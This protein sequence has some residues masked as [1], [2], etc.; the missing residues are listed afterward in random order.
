MKQ[1]AIRRLLSILTALAV[2]LTYATP[3]GVNMPFGEKI[4]SDAYGAE[5]HWADPFMNK[6]VRDGV[7]QGNKQGELNPEMGITRAEFITMINRAFGY[8]N[9]GANKFTDVPQDAW[10]ANDISIASKQGYFTGAENNLAK[11]DDVLKRE[12]AV[13]LLCRA[14][15]IEGSPEDNFKFSDSRDFSYW[16]KDYIYAATQKSYING[17]PDQTFK[18]ANQMKRGEMSKVLADVTGSLVQTSGDTT[19][20]YTA[21]NV[22]LNTSG[23]TLRNTTVPGDL[24]ITGGV[25][26][27]YTT[28]DN[29]TV[30][31]DLIVSGAGESNRGGDSIVL[32]DCNIRTMIIDSSSGNK[33]SVRAEGN[34]E[35][36][37]TMVKSNAYLEEANVRYSAFKDLELNGPSGT[38]LDLS[39]IFDSTIIYGPSNTLSLNK[40]YISRLHVDEQAASAKVYMEDTSEINDV[41]LDVGTAI[42][43]KGKIVNI[44]IGT[45]GSNV[46]MLPQNIAIRPGVTATINGKVM[47]STDAELNALKPQFT[48]GPTPD[49][50]MPTAADAIFQVNKPGKVYWMAKPYTDNVAPTSPSLLDLTQPK[51]ATGVKYASL[52]AMQNTNTTIKM[53][54]LTAGT[55]YDLF[56][57]LVDLSNN[58]SSIVRVP[59]TTTDNIT[60]KFQTGTPVLTPLATS[61]AIDY[62]TTKDATVYWA[63]LKSKTAAPLAADIINTAKPIYGAV[64]RGYKTGGKD[65]PVTIS[66]VSDANVLQ[67]TL[68]EATPYD[69][70]MVIKDYSGNISTVTKLSTNSLDVTAPKFLPSYPKAEASNPTTLV[71]RYSTDKDTTLY[72]AAYKKDTQFPPISPN[73]SPPA[74]G[75]PEELLAKQSAIMTGN[76]AFKFGKANTT[77]SKEGSANITGLSAQTLYDVYLILEDK[78]KNRSTITKLADLSTLDTTKPTA[79]LVFSQVINGNPVAGSDINLQFSEVVY[80]TDN[81]RLKDMTDAQ[82]ASLSSNIQLYDNSGIRP[83]LVN[84]TYGALSITEVDS[85]TV[86]T[87]NKNALNLSSG[88]KYYFILNNFKDSSNNKM[89]VNTKLP[90]F[91]TVPP[92]VDLYKQSVDNQ[93]IGFVIEPQVQNTSPSTRFDIILQADSN[94]EFELSVYDGS[95]GSYSST[96]TYTYPTR[97]LQKNIPYSLELLMKSTLDACAFPALKDLSKTQYA[98]KI[99]KMEGNTNR[100]SWNQNVTIIAKGISGSQDTLRTIAADVNRNL[101]SLINSKDAAV[102]TNPASVSIT[103]AFSDSITPSFTAGYPK[104]TAGDSG[105]NVKV[106]TDKEATFYWV[107]AESDKITT[108]PDALQ[109]LAGAPKT[110]GGQ[111]GNYAISSG[112]T[113][114]EFDIKGLKPQME[115][116]IY[117]LAKGTPAVK[118]ADIKSTKVTTLI[119]NKPNIT[120][121]STASAGDK[122]VEINVTSDSDGTVYWMIFATDNMPLIG[123]G[124]SSLNE[125]NLITRPGGLLSMA[126][127]SGNQAVAV[128]SNTVIRVTGLDEKKVYN[129]YATVQKPLSDSPADMKSIANVRSADKTPP[130]IA[131]AT[132]SID[133]DASTSTKFTGTLYIT[134][135][136]PLYYITDVANASSAALTAPIMQSMLSGLPGVTVSTSNPEPG[137]NAVRNVT[138][139]FSNA[140]MGAGMSVS[141]AIC[142]AY[143]NIAGQLVMTLVP[144]TDPTTSTYTP[145]IWK[146]EFKKN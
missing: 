30:L 132:T 69:I 94:I 100:D 64:I 133:L 34:T 53:A 139:N 99:T 138:I 14:L 108:T 97:T 18:P 119:V 107:L 88:N 57:V 104:F 45:N 6:L 71:L 73:T 96:P 78:S 29:V 37:R 49:N 110:Q 105:I 54:G 39:G 146:V 145:A 76:S 144:N 33:I 91:I 59:L 111:T 7:L 134:F 114:V 85:R 67:G 48:T 5:E 47:T 26:L 117:Y 95:S 121:I 75:S 16:S 80:T 66:T 41:F 112:G 135:S 40:G 136:E 106:N 63:V 13:T 20:G 32:K 128:N 124:E 1:K 103:K 123:P 68:L 137:T 143:S 101:T 8:K 19:V 86:V 35:I 42:T 90:E 15:K 142:D 21:G 28:L 70:Y 9:K 120:A 38:K 141:S 125:P 74:L 46:A 61:V 98:V 3:M 131:G 84:I 56:T 12:E 129:F 72:W 55:K 51:A 116:V 81:L 130:N 50:L 87:F 115:Y 2:C 102:V 118:N 65:L 113:E 4:L 60:P 89:D 23:T 52:N 10:Y 25:G 79:S 22:T 83:A 92:L 44:V 36:D 109:I 62:A 127:N 126:I 140:N 122:F 17:Y 93:D 82:K 43:G 27:G 24:Y 11:P 31:G 77:A 58:S